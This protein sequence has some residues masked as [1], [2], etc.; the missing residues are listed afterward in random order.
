MHRI[1]ANSAGAACWYWQR[2][3]CRGAPHRCPRGRNWRAL[4]RRQG[5]GGA[6]GADRG[7]GGGA[8]LSPYGE[9]QIST[10]RRNSQ[11]GA[12]TQYIASSLHCGRCCPRYHLANRRVETASSG[13][14]QDGQAASPPPA[15]ACSPAAAP[16][17]IGLLCCRVHNCRAAWRPQSRPRSPRLARPLAPRPR[18]RPPVAAEVRI[19]EQVGS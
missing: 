18:P 8:R 10:T 14:L 5:T 19:P 4:R 9:H 3:W 2:C 13:L 6:A 17:R 16:G 11:S 15:P 7:L 12:Y 1:R